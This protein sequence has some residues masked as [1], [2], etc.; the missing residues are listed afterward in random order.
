MDGWNG[1][2]IGLRKLIVHISYH[3]VSDQLCAEG[4][5]YGLNWIK[6]NQLGAYLTVG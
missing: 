5:K 6:W 2:C 3:P 4:V 1:S